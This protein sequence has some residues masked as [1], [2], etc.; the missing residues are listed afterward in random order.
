MIT[1]DQIYFLAQKN[2]ISEMVFKRIF[3]T[4]VSKR[5]LFPKP[6]QKYFFLKVEHP[7]I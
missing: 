1:K 3:S 4:F 7:C 2:K 6:K 5:A